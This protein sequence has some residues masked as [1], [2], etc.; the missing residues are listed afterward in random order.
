MEALAEPGLE[1][2]LALLDVKVLDAPGLD[3]EVAAPVVEVEALVAPGLESDLA[4]LG[5]GW[6]GVTCKAVQLCLLV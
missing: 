1:S 2:G 3:A 5:A 4:L 6:L